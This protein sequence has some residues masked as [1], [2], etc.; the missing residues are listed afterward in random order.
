LPEAA[1]LLWQSKDG[2]PP[3]SFLAFSPISTKRLA[4]PLCEAFPLPLL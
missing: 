2:L 3:R 4:P 1:P